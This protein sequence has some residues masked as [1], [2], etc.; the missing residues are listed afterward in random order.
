M[1]VPR[2]VACPWQM[3]GSVAIKSCQVGM[4]ARS[5]DLGNVGL[6]PPVENVIRPRRS[7]RSGGI[8]GGPA[9]GA[10]ASAALPRTPDDRVVA[11]ESHDVADIVN[12]VRPV[13]L[14]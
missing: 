10:W 12:V 2:I 11:V 5:R 13:A 8:P 9:S 7:V 1:R 14:V 4:C 3:A 6:D